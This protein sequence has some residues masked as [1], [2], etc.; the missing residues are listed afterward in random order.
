MHVG[1]VYIAYNQVPCGWLGICTSVRHGHEIVSGGHVNSTEDFLLGVTI[2]VLVTEMETGAKCVS[3]SFVG[4]IV[5]GVNMYIIF[6]LCYI[7]IVAPQI[8]FAFSV[9]NL[10]GD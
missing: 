5:V 8:T 1:S 7:S 4:A 2:D 3:Y 6:I 10:E 9:V